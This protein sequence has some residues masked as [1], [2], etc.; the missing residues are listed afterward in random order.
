MKNP[1]ILKDELSVLKLDKSAVVTEILRVTKELEL[2]NDQVLEAEVHLEGVKDNILQDTAR[3]D[4]IRGRAVSVKAELA[5]VSQDLKNS[6]ASYEV[7]KV[8]NSQEFKLHLG[9]IKELEETEE[10]ITKRISELKALY[11]KNSDT[12]AQNISENKG[13]LRT[14]QQESEEKQSQLTKVSKQLQSSLEE[15]KKLTKSR[16]KREDKV[17]A[18]EK[19]LDTRERVQEKI[20]EDI[21]TASRD[22]II[23][24][25]RLKELYAK[26]DPSVDLDK[27]ILQIE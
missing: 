2:V 21:T 23:V 6:I 12:Y 27:L 7:S 3:L 13:K 16:L 1:T 20:Q 9:R 5:T 19:L 11:D 15:D 17:R 18:R 22:I 24:Y 25:S 8:K 4:D 26:V 14:V 10:G